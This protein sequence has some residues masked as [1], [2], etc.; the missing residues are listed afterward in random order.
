MF[1]LKMEKKRPKIGL[2][3]GSG[4]A[5]GLTQIGILKVLKENNIPI[6]F[7]AGVS[8][9]SIVGA[10]Y[11]LNEDILGLEK[12][13]KAMSKK[14][15]FGLIDISSLKQGLEGKKVMEFLIKIL[16]E[17][18]FSDLKIPLKIVA[19]DLENGEEV[20]FD[21]GKLKDAI[22]ASIGIPGV[23]R[24]FKL[25]GKY[26]LDGGIVNPTPIDV[27]KKMGADI[28]IA[29]DHTTADYSKIKDL[30]SIN[31]LKRSYEII[32]TEMTKLKMGK[33][34]EDTVLISIK[35]KK[36]EDTYNFYNKRFIS[37][38]ERIAKEHL[39]QL[40]GMIDKWSEAPNI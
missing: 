14:E 31:A 4:G 37:E 26:Y 15:M 7:I 32:R 2:A 27:V 38:G 39:P 36:L 24:P 8:V 11:A 35:R 33:F 5:R 28:V 10:Y 3:L 29:V 23:F 6:D 21:D 13:V 18:T 19:T 25:N 22:R 20:W 40:K 17:K 34:E 1:K 9:G 12:S 30:N 16:G